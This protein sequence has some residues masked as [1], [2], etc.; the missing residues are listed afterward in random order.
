MAE[1]ES[2]RE[3][4]SEAKSPCQVTYYIGDEVGRGTALHFN[5]RGILVICNQPAPLNTKLKLLLEFPGF[6]HAIEIHGE[7]VWTNIY[8]APSSLAPR[9]MGVKFVN[10]EREVERMLADIAGI[11]ESFSSIFGCYYS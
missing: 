5:D 4:P 7:V 1:K 10:T 8:G 9:G 3:R 11:Y 2:V 6:K